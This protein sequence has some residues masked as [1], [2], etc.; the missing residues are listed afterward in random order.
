[1]N[2]LKPH[3]RKQAKQNGMVKQINQMPSDINK[4]D[5]K[6]SQTNSYVAILY[7]Q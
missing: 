7:L 4:Q 5:T 6:M 1:V 3:A 2:P